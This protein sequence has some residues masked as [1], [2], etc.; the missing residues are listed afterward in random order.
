M[1]SI[2]GKNLS[3]LGISLKPKNILQKLKAATVTSPNT[4]TGELVLNVAHIPL[5]A[6]AASTVALSLKPENINA[7]ESVASEEITQSEQTNSSNEPVLSSKEVAENKYFD[8][9]K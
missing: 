6:T 5:L 2:I 1:T 9:A 4:Q 3:K 7:D 8:V